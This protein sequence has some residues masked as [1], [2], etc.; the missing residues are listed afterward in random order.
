MI[1]ISD[2]NGQMEA[3]IA[4]DGA[5]LVSVKS[6]AYEYMWQANAKYWG[7]TAPVLFPFVGRLNQD[8]YTYENQEYPMGQH[9]FAR[10]MRFTV[11]SHEQ[12][13]AVLSLKSDESTLKRYPFAFELLISYEIINKD[14]KIGY[15]I[16]NKDDKR[17]Y[18]Q[19]GGHPAFNLDPNHQ[20]TITLT[21]KQDFYTLQ[22][23]YIDQL[24]ADVP[25]TYPVDVP[26][27]ANGALIF[28]P[29][30]TENKITL[31]EDGEP[32]IEMEY[33]DFGLMGVWTPEGQNAPFLCLEPW[34]GVADFANRQEFDLENKDY[35]NQLAA[36]ETTKMAYTISFK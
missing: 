17:M 36:N 20:Y 31:L 32:Y 16:R 14:L 12:T 18:Y 9:G 15:E 30:T 3:V 4:L 21:G 5:E 26:T 34:N 6:N 23:A 8:K 27:F 33:N 28:K 10:D 13:K 19:I 29:Q 2:M 1:T 35:I 24:Q 22:G 7:R 11:K 25:T